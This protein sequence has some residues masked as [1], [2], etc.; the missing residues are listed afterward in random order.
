MRLSLRLAAAALACIFGACMTDN[1]NNDTPA[2]TGAIDPAALGQS[3]NAGAA[4]LGAWQQTS[5]NPAAAV[6]LPTAA[7]PTPSAGNALA[8]PAALGK[9]AAVGDTV[10]YTDTSTIP[11]GYVTVCI[12]KKNQP[13]LLQTTYDTIVVRWD[14]QAQDTIAGNENILRL[15]ETVT[16]PLATF[17]TEVR[18]ADGDGLVNYVP[19]RPNRVEIKLTSEQSVLGQDVIEAADLAVDPGPDGNYD[20]LHQADNLID[21]A[22]WSRT[23]NGQV[24]AT[25]EFL[26]ADGDGVV[27]NN[28][29]VSIVTVKYWQLK[30]APGVDSESAT[31]RVLA[32]GYA[33]PTVPITF[34]YTQYLSNGRINQAYVRNSQGG[35]SLIADDTTHLFLTTQV[36]NQ[37]DT[38]QA[39][40]VEVVFNPGSDLNSDSDNVFYGLNVTTQKRLGWERAAEFHFTSATP[41][42][43]GQNPTAGNFS[44]AAT[45]ANGQ[46][47]TLAGSF[48]PSGYQATY[49]DPNGNTVNVTYNPSGQV[50]TNP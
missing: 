45:Y 20:S 24:Q 14:A 12:T 8:K 50:V 23:V 22:A 4:Y 10:T 37:N 5:A 11:A 26:D 3:L 39:A 33:Q 28:D 49:T 6:S 31:A 19:G 36:S 30:P 44:A 9:P 35:D 1:N 47:A 27:V 25:A 42:P 46:T 15:S 48:S 21:K 17:R 18:D 16:G 41:V 32:P 34:T 43:F 29:G 38:L 40:Q 2:V 13:T 7:L